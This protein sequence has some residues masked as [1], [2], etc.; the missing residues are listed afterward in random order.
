MT[1]DLSFFDQVN[2][3]FDRAAEMTDHPPGL[4]EQIKSVNSVIHF[5]FPLI[6]DDKTLQVIHAWRAEHSQH[7]LPTKGGIRYA[8]NVNED[9]V[10]ALSAPGLP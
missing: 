10:M 1:A 9:E 2:K 8:A 4:L 3:N 5:T 6:R 7:K